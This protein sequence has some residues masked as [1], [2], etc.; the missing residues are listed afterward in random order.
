MGEALR[1]SGVE[2]TD[3]TAVKGHGTGTVTNDR[4]EL[5]GLQKVFGG[6][7]PPFSSL[8]GLLGHTL[9]SCS[10]LETVLWAWCL[11]EGF[12]PA[13]LGFAAP[14]A[15]VPLQPLRTALRT[16]GRPGFHLFSAFG[17]GG[18]SV[19]YV[20]ADRGSP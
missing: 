15:D 17:F 9:G 14:E 3:L 5:R 8:K 2:R 6:A 16:D 18:T 13:S 19:S 12:V 7:V 4:S 10:A 1:L 11:E 20:L